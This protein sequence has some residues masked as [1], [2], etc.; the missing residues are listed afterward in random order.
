MLGSLYATASIK[1]GKAQEAEE[2]KCFGNFP[3]EDTADDG[4]GFGGFVGEESQEES[5]VAEDEAEDDGF[6]DF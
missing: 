5:V 2:G 4:G 1:A 3:G 6:G